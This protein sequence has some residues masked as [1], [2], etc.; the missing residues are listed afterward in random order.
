[1]QDTFMKA[2]KI[3]NKLLCILLETPLAGTIT[4]TQ[5]QLKYALAEAQK[6]Y[7]ALE[8]EAKQ[9]QTWL[10]GLLHHSVSYPS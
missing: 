8:K 6:A 3:Y 10:A 4:V 5:R 1:M 9:K 7:I 2:L